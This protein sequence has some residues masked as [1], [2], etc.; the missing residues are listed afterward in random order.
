MDAQNISMEEY[1]SG[2]R[3]GLLW[4]ITQMGRSRSVSD[5]SF[6]IA[7]CLLRNECKSHERYSEENEANAMA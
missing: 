5:W 3:L 1:Y 7:K 6:Y 4:L 2:V